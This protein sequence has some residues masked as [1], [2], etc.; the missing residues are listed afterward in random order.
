M[1]GKDKPV[2]LESYGSRR[3]RWR[4]PRWL[5][6]LLVGI[7]VGA[8]G[9]FF[10]QERYLPPR[11]SADAST[12]L[13]ASFEQA[14]ADRSR[15]KNELAD[16]AKRLQTA[17]A[18]QQRLGDE[19]SASRASVERLR[20]DVS[21]VVAGLPPDP[22]GGAIEVRA[23][24]FA[25]KGG[26][27]AYEVVLTREPAAFPPMSGVMQLVVAGS[28][29]RGSE[30]TLPLKPV[31]LAI[32]NH[33]ILRGSLPLPEGFSPRQATVQVLDRVG[34]KLLGMRVMLVR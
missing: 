15:L 21:A 32:S 5:V 10:I 1:F 17:V 3:S 18:E 33:E 9:L 25:T 26:M 14:D 19:L 16:T 7:G 11:L 31:A 4:V 22:R 2:V 28:S 8:G 6:L 30:T 24:R 27:L 29:A 20:E 34:G 12:A 23:G 13:R